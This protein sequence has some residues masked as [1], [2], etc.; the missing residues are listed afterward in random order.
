[1]IDMVTNPDWLI[2]NQRQEDWCRL[3]AEN[4]FINCCTRPNW[5]R[6]N[7]EGC[8][9]CEAD[10]IH[11]QMISLCNTYFGTACYIERKPFAKTGAPDFMTVETVCLPEDCLTDTDEPLIIPWYGQQYANRRSGWTYDFDEVTI[12]C[13]SSAGAIIFYVILALLGVAAAGGCGLFLF[14]APKERG[15]TLIDQSE[16]NADQEEMESTMMSSQGYDTAGSFGA[17]Q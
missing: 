2:M 13:P 3:K 6:G 17:T 16:M 7:A 12:Y 10:C 14:R 4:E 9:D 11:T 5:E 1:M 15:Q 8:S